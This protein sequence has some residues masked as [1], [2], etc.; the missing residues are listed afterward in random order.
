MNRIFKFRVWN[1]KHK[2]W[3]NHVAVID[4]PGN[5]GSHF[6]AVHDDGR[7]EQAIVG[8]PKEENIIQQFTGLTDKNG[9][10]IY[11]GDVIKSRYEILFEC[12]FNNDEA[13][14]RMKEIKDLPYD[15]N[16]R[17]SSAYLDPVGIADYELEVIGN[18]YENPELLTK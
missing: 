1:L 8:L 15:G 18:I 5:I 12:Y 10:E 3:I 4:C 7:T 14:F 16:S 17:V 13:S 9:K 2:Q 11:E 6:V